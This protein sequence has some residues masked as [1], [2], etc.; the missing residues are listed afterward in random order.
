MAKYPIS[1]GV[2]KNVT[3]GEP[4]VVELHR[5]LG[6]SSNSANVIPGKVG[7]EASPRSTREGSDAPGQGKR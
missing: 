1:K 7:R 6:G 4:K 3:V 2:P 5:K